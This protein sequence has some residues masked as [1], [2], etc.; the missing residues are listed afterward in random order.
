MM[1]ML[2]TKTGSERIIYLSKSCYVK[3]IESRIQITGLALSEHELTAQLRMD[4]E[5]NVR[6]LI[7]TPDQADLHSYRSYLKPTEGS[8]MLAV[9][10][11][12]NAEVPLLLA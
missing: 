10:I 11:I 8:A 7:G 3:G 12:Q 5:W 2:R 6:A 4:Y 9:L 1:L